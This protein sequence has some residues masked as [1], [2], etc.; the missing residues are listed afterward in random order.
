MDSCECSNELSGPL[1][2]G[3]FLDYL[4]CYDLFKDDPSSGVGQLYCT[5]TKRCCVSLNNEITFML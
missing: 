5:F 3:E 1:R 2:V 4:S